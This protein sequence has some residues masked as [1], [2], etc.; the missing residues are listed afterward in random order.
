MEIHFT[1]MHGIGND[2]IYI[3]CLNGIPFDPSKLSRV[4]SPRHFSVGADG[5][6]LICS[7][8]V[9]DAKMRMFNLDGSEGKMCGNAIRCV[10]KYLYEKN[11]VKKQSVTIETLSGIKALTLHIKNDTVDTV[12]VNMGYASFD[13]AAVPVQSELPVIN[14]PITVKTPCG[15]MTVPMTAVSV[16]NPHAVCYVDDPKALELS[17]IG[18]SF[19]NLSIFPERVNT[20][21][22]SIIGENHL[23]MRVWER[24]SGETYA[25]GTGAC[26]VAA[27]SV[28]NGICSMNENVTVSL[29]GGDLTICISNDYEIQMTGKAA[30]VYEGVYSYED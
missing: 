5:I 20:E 23:N 18:P 24:G 1:K 17:K 12:S 2:Y 10:G 22:V 30:F 3:N 28:K 8:L 25:C 15:D 21:F 14:K 7:S 9:A 26:A 19:E 13:P 16:G 11:I 27:A 4:M 6:V 29:I